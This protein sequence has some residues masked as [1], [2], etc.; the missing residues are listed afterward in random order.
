MSR[1]SPVDDFKWIEK[2]NL[3][4]FDEKFKKGYDENSGKGYILKLDVEYTK[5][6][7]KL[8]RDLPEI[9]LNK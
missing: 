9:Y 3:S 2:E 5:K 8:H 6:F 4:K 1:K 7:H